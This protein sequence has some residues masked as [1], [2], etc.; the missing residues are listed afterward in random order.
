MNLRPTK[1]LLSLWSAW[2]LFALAASL[3]PPAAA[4]W[5]GL[6]GAILLISFLDAASLYLGKK[7]SVKREVPSRFA[8]GVP[9]EVGLRLENHRR[10]RVCVCLF[11]G[12]PLTGEAEDLPWRDRVDARSYAELRYLLTF[13]ERGEVEFSRCHLLESS[14]LGLWE[15]RHRLGERTPTKVYP[16]YQ[17]VLRFALMAVAQRQEQ[18]GIVRKNRA[19]MSRDF[20]QLR[21]YQQGDNLSQID[22]K[23]S[24]KRR[25]LIARDYQEQRDQTVIFL[26]DCG[27][28][29][30][31]MDGELS[32]FDH[33]LNALLFLSYVALRQGDKVGILSFGGADRWLLPVKGSQSMTT[34]LNHLYDYETAPFPSDFSEAAERL[35][36]HQHKRA[37]VV[38]VSNLRG[39]DGDDL[40]SPLRRLRQKHLVVLASLRE[41]S[42]ARHEA[43]EVDDV[44]SA[45]AWLAIKDYGR[46]RAEVLRKLSAH[47]VVTVDETAQNFPV[48]LAN[49]YLDLRAAL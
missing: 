5:W 18:M 2:L 32:Q 34:V 6:A 8:L 36:R 35:M 49:R 17:P 47:G 43:A 29:M 37:M 15:R 22:W 13:K 42:L 10:R 27:R 24:S 7:P 44:D 1:W 48:A 31:A 30:R 40:V 26:V 4:F 46:E 9:A 14:S 21:D 19:G 28:R 3:W 33:T 25:S 45:L 41:Q 12:V 20:H 11:D 23:A 39:E 38:V 16:N